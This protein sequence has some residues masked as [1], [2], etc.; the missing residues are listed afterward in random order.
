[1]LLEKKNIWLPVGVIPSVRGKPIIN[2]LMSESKCICHAWI[3][4]LRTTERLQAKNGYSIIW[5]LL[6][7]LELDLLMNSGF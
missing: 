3:L 1:M 2:P 7:D 5:L 6:D 4:N